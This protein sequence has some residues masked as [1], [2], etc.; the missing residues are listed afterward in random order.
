MHAVLVAASW[1]TEPAHVWIV[2]SFHHL[3]GPADSLRWWYSA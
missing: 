2:G 1:S 3:T